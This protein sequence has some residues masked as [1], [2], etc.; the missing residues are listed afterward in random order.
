MRSIEEDG[1]KYVGLRR[2]SRRQLLCALAV[3]L[4][5][6]GAF[7]ESLSAQSSTVTNSWSGPL[8]DLKQTLEKLKVRS[9]MQERLIT[10][11]QTD[12]AELQQLSTEQQSD[13]RRQQEM[14]SRSQNS[15]STAS[16]SWTSYLS[17]SEVVIRET[18]ERALRAEKAS[19]RN[20]LVWQ[21]GVPLALVTGVAIGVLVR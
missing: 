19:R 1:C 13:L 9:V 6:G 20:R 18:T 21:I 11:L 2:L 3:V 14:L 8:T 12:N 10:S 16:Q 4:A 17:L 15:L 5:L 7:G